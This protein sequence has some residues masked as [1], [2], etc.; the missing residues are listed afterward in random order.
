MLKSQFIPV[1]RLRHSRSATGSSVRTTCTK[2]R[3]AAFALLELREAVEGVI[4]D[5]EAKLR[6]AKEDRW[7]SE[8]GVREI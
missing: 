2:L 3:A 8:R 7:E 5:A 4:N 6:K 1:V